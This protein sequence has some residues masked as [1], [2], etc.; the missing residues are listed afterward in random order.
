MCAVP[1][2]DKLRAY[3]PYKDNA[4]DGQVSPELTVD[5]AGVNY[6][7]DAT[8]TEADD[9]WN[10]AIIRFEADTTTS[11]LQGTYHHVMDFVAAD[12]KLIFAHDMPATPVNTDTFRIFFGGSWRTSHEIPGFTATGLTDVTGVTIDHACYLNGAGNGTLEYD[13]APTESLR[14]TAPD[15]SNPGAWVDVS[16]AGAGTSYVLYSEDPDKFL[17]VTVVYASLPVGDESD[18]IALAQPEGI[19]IP[20]FEGY[21]FDG[22]NKTR[23]HLIPI[24]N[25]DAADSMTDLRVWVV[26]SDDGTDST[27]TTTRDNTAGALGITDASDWPERSFWVYNSTRTDCRFVFYRSGNTCY[28]AA[29]GAGLRGLTSATWQIGD[30][31]EVMPDYDI[32]IDAP[33]TNQFEDP[34]NETTAPS[35][36]AFSA[37]DDYTTGLQI[38]TLA[39]GGIYGVW[40]RETIVD[41]AHARSGIA[42]PLYF[43]WR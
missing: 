13:S 30:S 32:G 29:A 12:D 3:Y 4:S 37:P 5:S 19:L 23:Y 6:V 34:A 16:S 33:S 10:G 18:T 40:T 22:S 20:D 27:T 31:V 26:P 24:K 41:E 1:T 7:V 36:I 14:W 35:G 39:S 11:A 42:P 17:E 25:N 8:L 38:G 43:R 2:A 9:Y 28:C 15:D 21:E